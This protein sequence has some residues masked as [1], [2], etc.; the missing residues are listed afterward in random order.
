MAPVVHEENVTS[1]AGQPL[2][3][4]C[5][6]TMIPN[7]VTAPNVEWLNSTDSVVSESNTLILLPLLTSHGGYHTCRVIVSIPQL[8]VSLTA[9]AIIS[10]T[11][12][13]ELPPSGSDSEGGCSPLPSHARQSM[14]ACVSL[15]YALRC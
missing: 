10:I 3:I 7:L 13:S 11:V 1:T 5:N 6:F 2:S 9:E 15:S 12:Q 8:N 14:N 4:Q